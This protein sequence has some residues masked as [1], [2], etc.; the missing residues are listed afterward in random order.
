MAGLTLS[1]M[2][3]I[4]VHQGSKF[5]DSIAEAELAFAQRCGQVGVRK[6]FLEYF[7]PRGIFFSPQPGFAA[8]DLANAPDDPQPLKTV[9]DWA[10]AIVDVSASGDMG[11]TTGPLK[12]RSQDGSKPPSFGQYFSVWVREGG[13]KPWKVILDFGTK[14]MSEQP[15]PKAIRHRAA[16]ISSGSAKPGASAN[17]INDLERKFAVSAKSNL[18]GQA[19]LTLASPNV[20]LHRDGLDPIL[21]AAESKTYYDR[22]R[23]AV[24][25][26]PMGTGISKSGDM[27][28][29]YGKYTLIQGD[30]PVNGYFARV[31]KRDSA[32]TWKIVA[33]IGNV[34]QS[35]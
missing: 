29:S 27:G 17:E 18:T 21:G 28:Y 5:H 30:E 31:W 1:S 34:V 11:Y 25:W 14:T 33:D 9:L 22:F 6:S 23:E 32:G 24:Q 3:L 35:S 26:M 19:F 16:E 8:I 2:A 13:Q 12:I 10:P 4:Q 7:H 15:E 20:R